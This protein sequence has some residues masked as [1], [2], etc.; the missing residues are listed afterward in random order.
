M[1]LLR[2]I[3]SCLFILGHQQSFIFAVSES[4]HPS[5]ASTDRNMARPRQ[6]VVPET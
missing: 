1:D 2:E 3:T 5:M 6:E 4:P